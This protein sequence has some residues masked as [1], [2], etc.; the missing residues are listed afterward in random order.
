M[1]T[2]IY[3]NLHNLILDTVANVFNYYI[4]GYLIYKNVFIGSIAK[5]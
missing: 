3:N 2:L 5:K 1:A 4:I